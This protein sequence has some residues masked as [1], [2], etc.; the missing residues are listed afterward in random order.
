MYMGL[1]WDVDRNT[2]KKHYRHYYEDELENVDE[3]F[4]DGT[5]FQEFHLHRG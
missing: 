1:G 4:Q 2:K 3:V 5:P